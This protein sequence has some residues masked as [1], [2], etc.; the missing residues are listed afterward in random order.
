MT[1]NPM[2]ASDILCDAHF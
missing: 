2:F 1:S